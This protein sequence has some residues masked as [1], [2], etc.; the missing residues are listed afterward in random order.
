MAT[1]DR[2]T[3]AQAEQLAELFRE[4][5][6]FVLRLAAAQL[7]NDPDAAQDLA[8]SVWLSIIPTLARGE[9]IARPHSF[10]AT[11]TRRRAADYRDRAAVR[12]ERVADWSDP[13]AARALPAESPADADALAF[14]DL[15]KP[16]AAVLKLT[17]QGLSTRAIA[18]RLGQGRS[19]IHRTLH[20]G[21]R[22]LRLGM[23]A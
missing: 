7:H 9:A 2:L 10:L 21:A 11:V 14:A 4:Y 8:Q 12:R 22:N 16:Q 23:A 6:A 5:N 3:P 13:M 19:H 17:A 15:S 18:R 20:R 1:A